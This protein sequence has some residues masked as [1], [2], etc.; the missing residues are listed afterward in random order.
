MLALFV[1]STLDGWANLYHFA[2]DATAEP[3]LQPRREAAFP[4][5]LVARF[6]PDPNHTNP[7]P[8]PNPSPDPN[9]YPDPSPDP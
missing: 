3:H 9:P 5:P 8:S 4:G 6:N 1:T 2:M 7:G